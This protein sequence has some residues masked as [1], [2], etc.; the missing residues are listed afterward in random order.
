MQRDDTA[1]AD[2]PL[3]NSTHAA[4]AHRSD[5]T[6]EGS[7]TAPG[8]GRAIGQATQQA[9]N[10]PATTSDD[11]TAH[12]QGEGRGAPESAGASASEQEVFRLKVRCA[13]ARA[14][15]LPPD[16]SGLRRLSST[17]ALFML[18]PHLCPADVDPDASKQ[19]A[20]NKALGARDYAAAVKLYTQALATVGESIAGALLITSPCRAAFCSRDSSDLSYHKRYRDPY[21]IRGRVFATR[22]ASHRRTG[23]SRRGADDARRRHCQMTHCGMSHVC[24]H[25]R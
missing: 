14:A 13:E 21:E 8:L 18:S 7:G 12:G 25:R 16:V 3:A 19:D 20:G 17:S 9:Q 2:P 22:P 23:A 11:T 15:T 24:P 6:D 5:K 1:S 4:G 10:R